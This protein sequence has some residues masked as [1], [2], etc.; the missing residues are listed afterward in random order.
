MALESK[1]PVEKSAAKNAIV[2]IVIW[3]AIF[4]AIFSTDAVKNFFGSF[5]GVMK[6]NSYGDVILISQDNTLN[7]A[8][9]NA[10]QKPNIYNII[11]SPANANVFYA[12]SD[13]GIYVSSDNGLNW[14]QIK[15]PKE[16]GN[17]PAIYNLSANVHDPFSIYFWIFKDKKAV[18]YRTQDSF[19]SIKEVFEIDSAALGTLASGRNVSSA[20]SS[21]NLNLIGTSDK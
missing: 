3:L 16:L 7:S 19:F 8:K 14:Y 21:G 5:F 2:L 15:L 12:G 18:V 11:Q 20:F 1:P 4:G 10:S 13:S 9:F 6:I 17:N